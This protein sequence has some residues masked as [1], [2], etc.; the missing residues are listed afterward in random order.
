[1]KGD[2]EEREAGKERAGKW[3]S[4]KYGTFLL[5]LYIGAKRAQSLPIPPY[6]ALSYLS[7]PSLL[8]LHLPDILLDAR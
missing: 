2:G 1:M 6:P 4:N 3:L 5:R 7:M 8:R